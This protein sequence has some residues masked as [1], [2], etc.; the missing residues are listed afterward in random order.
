MA[1]KKIAFQTVDKEGDIW[2]NTAFIFDNEEQV[3]DFFAD[4][5]RVIDL[6]GYEINEDAGESYDT[7][8]NV[9]PDSVCIKAACIELEY[10]GEVWIKR[11]N[12]GFVI[13]A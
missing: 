10:C 8:M 3:R 4:P 12:G 13:N 6:L 7:C 9:I 5:K 1:T 2:C 11:M